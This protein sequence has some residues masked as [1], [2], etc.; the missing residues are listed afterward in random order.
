MSD[1]PMEPMDPNAMTIERQD[2]EQM[3]DSLRDMIQTGAREAAQ[4][5]LAQLQELLENLQIGQQSSQMQQGQQMMNQ[6]QELIQRQQ[7]LLDET[8]GLSRQPGQ[9][10]SMDR[11]GQEGQQGQQGQ[12][13][14]QMGQQPG[15][16][17]GGMRPGQ[18]P[19]QQGQGL[20]MDQESLRRALGELMR[21]LGENGVP[22]PRAMGEAELS[23]REARDALQ[24]GQPGQALDPQANALDQLR[25]GGQAMMQE[26]QRMMGQ[27]QGPG[28]PNQGQQFG[29]SPTDR[30]PFGR[31]L[32]NRGEADLFGPE[33]PSDLDLGK[34]RAI[35]EELH[36]RAGQRFRPSE[37]LDYLERLLRRF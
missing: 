2:L 25:Q 18:Q 27:Q 11:P 34:A 8:F 30:D 5:M 20:A 37:E 35:M 15:Q 7:D 10:G 13:Q 22:I 33:V 3:L 21:S 31:P 19:G 29:Q 23:M 32:F 16:M 12:Q 1:Q 6:L 36:R 4:E 9:E 26:M 17:P 24:G 14:G 28:Q